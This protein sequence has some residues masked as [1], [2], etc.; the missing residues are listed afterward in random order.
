MVVEGGNVNVDYDGQATDANGVKVWKQPYVLANTDSVFDRITQIS[1]RGG[2]NYSAI[3]VY[4][5]DGRKVYLWMQSP[6]ELES[7]SAVPSGYSSS[8]TLRGQPGEPLWLTL[9]QTIGTN[10]RTLYVATRGMSVTIRPFAHA[11]TAEQ[12]REYALIW[13][14]SDDGLNWTTIENPDCDD[15]CQLTYK[16]QT[17]ESWINRTFR[18]ELRK[19][20]TNEQLGVYTATLHIFNPKIV[21]ETP[22]SE[23]EMVRLRLVE[24]TLPPDG[25]GVTI[26][27]I[28]WYISDD[29]GKNYVLHTDANGKEVYS[30]KVTTALEGRVIRCEAQLSD[31]TTLTDVAISETITVEVTDRW[32]EIIKQPESITISIPTGDSHTIK[33][34]D[35]YATSYQ[36][37]VSKRTY[38]GE[39]VPFEDIPGAN[40]YYYALRSLNSSQQYYAY[41][42]VVSND[43]SEAITDEVTVTLL[44]DPFFYD[45]KGF[46]TTIREGEDALFETKIMGGNPLVAT[47]IY[48]E[49][50]R[51]NGGY[52]RLS[53][54]EELRDYITVESLTETSGGITYHTQATLRITGVTLDM[55]GWQF[56]CTMVYGDGKINNWPV[57]NLK[58]L[59]ECQQ[60][61]HDWADPTCTAP[62]T[63]TRCGETQGEALGHKGGVATCISC[64]V[65]EVCGEEYGD[66][67][68][69]NHPAD[70][71]DVW[72]VEDWQDDAGHHSKWSCCGRPKYPYEYH[73]WEEGICT[74][75][76][77]ICEHPLYSPGNCHERAWCHICHIEFSQID[78]D[79]HDLET[80]GTTVRDK[81]DP[82]CTED[83]YTGDIICWE[84]HGVVTPG[85]VL[86][87][88]GHSTSWK[89]TCKEPAYCSDCQSWY[90]DPDPDNHAEPW[91]AYYIKT[92]EQHEQHWNC[93]DKVTT[94]PHDFRDGGVCRV[95]L[96]GCDHS[97]GTATCME[98]ALCDHCGDPYGTIDPD[99]HEYADFMWTEETHTGVCM[100]GAITS[101]TTAHTWENGICTVC[102]YECFHTGGRATCTEEALCSLC[103]ERYGG[104]A[105]HTYSPA[106]S[107]DGENHWHECTGC[108]EK[109]DEAAHTPGEAAT[110][111][112][113]QVCTVCN[114]ELAPA[115]GHTHDFTLQIT[116]DKYLVSA[117]TCTAKA[118]YRYSCA[119]GAGGEETFTSG[120]TTAHRYDDSV[121]TKGGTAHW[122][123][124]L[125]CGEEIGMAA[126]E[127]T[128]GNHLCD[129]CEKTLGICED[130]DHNHFCDVCG[131][132]LSKHSGGTATCK[133]PATCTVCGKAYGDVGEHIYADTWS[134][135]GE[136]HW[137]TC[138]VCGEAY[139]DAGNHLY[140]AAWSHDETHHWHACAVCDHRNGQEAHTDADG[141]H[142]CDT[143]GKAFTECADNDNDHKCDVCGKVLSECADANNDHKC[144]LCGKT[145]TECT[146][147]D[148]DHK[149]DV[150][151]KVLSECADGNNDHKCDLCG[152]TLSE[153]TDA[154]ND[155]KCDVCGKVLSECTDGNNDHKC[156]V[157][158]KVLSE[159]GDDPARKSTG[160]WIAGIAGGTTTIG[161]GTALVLF[162]LRKKRL[163]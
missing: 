16:V 58:V 63:C 29:G 150:C 93:C 43:F 141:D 92:A 116:E 19:T 157:C 22:F 163:I 59:T 18:C 9:F 72:N 103:D 3:G 101:P 144:D 4:P 77:C 161:I 124:C 132:M 119:C 37:Q 47:E 51:G 140:E 34:I 83:G 127:D 151:G 28:R 76:G 123:L 50:Y 99:N 45:V 21:N 122:H 13:S 95:C 8:L 112:T 62:S 80:L 111:N 26:E 107:Q 160:A 82:T 149:C 53:E 155:H 14:Y 89:A 52:V 84:C 109:A 118:V 137:H 162:I 117:A 91:S 100:C 64:A 114:H 68:R 138:T 35:R 70:A 65:C 25:Q 5:I 56:R 108:G 120:E 1:V 146:D 74:V 130:A 55:N 54:I 104:T 133:A 98:P 66:F 15:E 75:C 145:L 32:V 67:D 96:Y 134:H 38:P 86:P 153:C 105:D 143:C 10:E 159:E 46:S 23:N 36:W 12:M 24:G 17:G 78:P 39:N 129:T 102:G 49:V 94:A 131:R 139:E 113:P 44:Y 136:H 87:A 85:T 81:K 135:D 110:E 152:K 71:T 115:T 121:W 147:A 79:N 158:G 88:K 30:F 156:D 20:A 154:D 69:E 7:L 90:G 61:G 31:G 73:K 97:G 125:D 33:V 6:E 11:P 148:N 40:K 126:H 106:W 2:R 27:R 48:W 60:D 128:D 57:F 142:R 42:C 41:R